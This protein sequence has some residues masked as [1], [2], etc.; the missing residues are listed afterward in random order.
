MHR[1]DPQLRQRNNAAGANRFEGDRVDKCPLLASSD[2]CPLTYLCQWNALVDEHPVYTGCLIRVRRETALIGPHVCHNTAYLYY[3][4]N[5]LCL[6]ARKLYY[7]S[8]IPGE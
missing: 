1:Q 8:L 5:R 6:T 3:F 2:N 4:L 7:V